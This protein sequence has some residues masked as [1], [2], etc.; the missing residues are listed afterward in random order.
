MITWD[1]LNDS[2]K[3]DYTLKEDIIQKHLPDV[4][5]Y[6]SNKIESLEEELSEAN[7]EAEDKQYEVSRLEDTLGDRDNEIEKLTDQLEYANGEI[8]RLEEYV[9]TLEEKNND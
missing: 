3:Y 1:E 2:F 9:K 7:S 4:Y 5:A 8:I 6:Y